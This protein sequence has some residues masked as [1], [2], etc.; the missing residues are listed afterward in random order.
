M[1]TGHVLGDVHHGLGPAQ[2]QRLALGLTHG[3]G[4]VLATFNVDHRSQSLDPIQNLK[5]ALMAFILTVFIFDPLN[6][7][8]NQLL[9]GRK[10]A[11]HFFVS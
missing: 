1:Y 8:L 9:L 3:L 4:E 2:D 7:V 11:F 5:G 6:L 10:T